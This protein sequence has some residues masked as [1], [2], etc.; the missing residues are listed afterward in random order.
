MSEG[1]KDAALPAKF[2][3]AGFSL[4]V[5]LP[6]LVGFSV[7]RETPVF[8]RNEGGYPIW[9]R[10]FVLTTYYP[11][12]L[13]NFIVVTLY[14]VLLVSAPPRMKRA[15]LLQFVVLAIMSGGVL[16]SVIWI[17]LDDF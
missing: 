4:F 1:L 3:L 10:D 15:F 9:L 7:L 2:G 14:G 17:I 13:L 8:W 6:V 16:F 5:G 11:I 12:L